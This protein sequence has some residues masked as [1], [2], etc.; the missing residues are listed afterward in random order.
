MQEG[1]VFF[2]NQSLGTKKDQFI[3]IRTRRFLVYRRSKG[4]VRDCICTDWTRADG[5][6]PKSSGQMDNHFVKYS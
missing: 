6:N 5:S 3:L 2:I 1:S 4:C